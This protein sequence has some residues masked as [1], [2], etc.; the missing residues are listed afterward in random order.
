M[1]CTRLRRF[2]HLILYVNILILTV[3]FMC[4]IKDAWTCAIALDTLDT[5]R[6]LAL[7]ALKHFDIDT[8]K[9]SVQVSV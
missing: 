5:W 4:R 9:N 6:E 8:G 7:A 2:V 3:R 1:K